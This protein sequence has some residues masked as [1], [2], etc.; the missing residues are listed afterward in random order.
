MPRPVEPEI[1][2]ALLDYETY[3]RY[4]PILGKIDNFEKPFIAVLTA[5]KE[6]Y[7]KYRDAKAITLDELR[8]FAL[9]MYPESAQDNLTR[10]FSALSEAVVLNSDLLK[11]RLN[12]M[13]AKYISSQI[14]EESMRISEDYHQADFSRI[15]ELITKYKS[16]TQTVVDVEA[17]VCNTP[18]SELVL[19]QTLGGIKWRIEA[20]NE[21][22]GPL[23][24]GILGHV[25]A[26]SETGKTT[27]ALSEATYQA[28]QLR[29]GT[30]CV[31]Y[32]NNEESVERL[33]VRAFAAMLNVSVNYLTNNIQEAERIFERK[34]GG[35]LKMIGEV[36]DIA[37]VDHYIN[38][39]KP[40]ICWV[41]QGPKLQIKT[42]ANDVM[43][44][45]ILYQK[46]R[47][48]AT[49]YNCAIITLGQADSSADNRQ[50]LNLNQLDY[51]K[52]GIPAELD[53]ALGIGKLDSDEE[54]RFLQVCKNKLTGKHIRQVT[55]INIDTS[56]YV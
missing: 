47:Q 36:R 3:A 11:D 28:E 41:D 18:L 40:K 24:G 13:L 17:D 54:S 23:R 50:W 30:D 45:S 20:L 6:Y 27:F 29:A 26:R 55:K 32:L 21:H 19:A 2:K 12:D 49:Q 42:D 38:T 44:L 37:L 39:F 51:S 52:V 43:R 4:A 56:R 34:G 31:L 16:T 33:K 1:L 10:T 9:A 48:L 15:E 46:L 22:P 5:I 7:N 25:F 14:T 8:I 35:N 53:F